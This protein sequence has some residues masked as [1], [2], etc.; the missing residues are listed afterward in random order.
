MEY[1]GSKCHGISWNIETELD[2]Y[3]PENSLGDS[4]LIGAIVFYT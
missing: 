4:T 3:T 2:A 1:D